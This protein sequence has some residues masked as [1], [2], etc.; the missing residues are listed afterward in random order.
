MVTSLFMVLSMN[1]SHKLDFSEINSGPQWN[2]Y[3]SSGNEHYVSLSH[4]AVCLLDCAECFF[5]LN[6][7]SVSEFYSLLLSTTISMQLSNGAQYEVWIF[8]S[9]FRLRLQIRVE[10]GLLSVTDRLKHYYGTLL[11]SDLFLLNFNFRWWVPIPNISFN[12][13]SNVASFFA[14]LAH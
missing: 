13:C 14:R 11:T 2:D 9:S 12:N 4:S 8:F 10:L 6:Y 5:F 7:L 1:S 3:C